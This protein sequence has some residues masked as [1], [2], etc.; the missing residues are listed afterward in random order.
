MYFRIAN[1]K[2]FNSFVKSLTN[3][4]KT[5]GKPSSAVDRKDIEKLTAPIVGEGKS[6]PVLIAE[7]KK[8]PRSLE[9]VV[10]KNVKGSVAKNLHSL[11]TQIEMLQVYKSE[12]ATA[13]EATEKKFSDISWW[14]EEFDENIELMK[15]VQSLSDTVKLDN[16][17][18]LFEVTIDGL[19]Y[20]IE[21]GEFGWRK[22]KA[23]LEVKWAGYSLSATFD[24]EYEDNIGRHSTSVGCIKV[25]GE[26]AEDFIVND[27]E[28][29]FNT[30][31]LYDTLEEEMTLWFD[32]MLDAAIN[33]LSCKIK[34]D[35]SPELLLQLIAE[36][37]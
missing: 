24:V 21:S 27:E 14:T 8:Q 5:L 35:I 32:E 26:D 9:G 31:G 23:K 37:D 30:E 33:D 29:G 7:M 36:L 10:A 12:L 34:S 18:E 17:N 6:H 20:L 3:G 11:A 19:D 13:L 22:Y 25:C 4:I 2:E 28:K 1:A 15:V 16:R